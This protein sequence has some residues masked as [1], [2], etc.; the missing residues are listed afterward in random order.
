MAG[1][2]GKNSLFR[3]CRRY[4]IGGVDLWNEVH[5]EYNGLHSPD[6][7]QL[8]GLRVEYVTLVMVPNS[9]IPWVL[10]CVTYFHATSL[11]DRTVTLGW[12]HSL[13][14]DE[15]APRLSQ[16][17]MTSAGGEAHYD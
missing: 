5:G 4:N 9:L 12:A 1:E 8:S 13:N 10:K 15:S 11:A 7:G 17:P 6:L 3:S 16:A 2:G 14:C